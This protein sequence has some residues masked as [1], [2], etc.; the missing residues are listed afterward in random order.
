[1]DVLESLEDL[2]KKYSIEGSW[3]LRN[4]AV[5]ENVF[6]KFMDGL[7]KAPTFALAIFGLAAADEQH[8]E[9]VAQAFELS[10]IVSQQG[11]KALEASNAR[12]HTVV[13]GDSLSRIAR[14]YYGDMHKWP[15]IF[16][17]NRAVIGRNPNIIKPG[18]KLIIPELPTIAAR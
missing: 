18:E 8:H 7:S 14:S 6:A 15:V 16:E 5:M 11:R 12:S 1:M 9:T 10:K 17:A 13:A 4:A 2:A 3:Q